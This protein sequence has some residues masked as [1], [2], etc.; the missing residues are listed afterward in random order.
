MN[1][2]KRHHNRRRR[3]RNM[4]EK[5]WIQFLT[6]RLIH[7]EPMHGYKIIE[8]LEDRGYV[9]SRR[10]RSGSIYVILKRM[11]HHGLLTSIRVD[12][13][14]RRSPRVY[15]ITDKGILELVDG[16]KFVLKRRRINDEL[17]NY[18]KENFED[19]NE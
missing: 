16:L 6:L 19:A 7:E 2:N 4:P 5:A 10:L 12:P 9:D 14:D 11:E 15:S 13:D 18:Y 3:K 1:S 17:I 8:E